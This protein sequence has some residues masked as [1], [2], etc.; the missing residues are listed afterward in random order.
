MDVYKLGSSSHKVVARRARFAEFFFLDLKVLGWRQYAFWIR[1]QAAREPLCQVLVVPHQSCC[2]A[3]ILRG[4]LALP[5]KAK[6][7]EA[8]VSLSPEPK[9]DSE[10]EV[11][12]RANQTVEDEEEVSPTEHGTALASALC[13][14]Y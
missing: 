10:E 8:K 7:A 6:M 2:F 9:S 12:Y 11:Q 4:P 14:S 3:E 5:L 13:V 1:Q